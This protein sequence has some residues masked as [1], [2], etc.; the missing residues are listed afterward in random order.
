VAG[1]EW[2][3]WALGAWIGAGVLIGIPF[4]LF[5]VQRIDPD[6]RGSWT[7][8]LVILPGVAALWPLILTWWVR[9]RSWAEPGQAP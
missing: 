8:R 2:V 7:F 1:A 4:V 3:L 6:A 9:G 5:G